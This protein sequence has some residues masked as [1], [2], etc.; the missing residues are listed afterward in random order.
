MPV[1]ATCIAALI[2][3]GLI[4]AQTPPKLEP[5]KTVVTVTARPEPVE[6]SAAD[7]TVVDLERSPAASPQSFADILR[8]QPGLYIGQTG[9]R[10]GLTVVSLRGGDPNFTLFMLDG[11]PVN[12][13]TDQLGGTVDLS[14]IL[15]V[16]VGRVEVVRGPMSVL[17][18]SEAVAGVINVISTDEPKEHAA[19]RL[20]TGSF[21]DLDGGFSVGGRKGR[22]QYNL[23]IAGV[24][25]GEQVERDSFS[26]IDAG[27][28]VSSAIGSNMSIAFIFRIR[29]SEATGFPANSGGP[30]YALNRALETRA[31][32]SG[33][34]G[35]EWKYSI[36]R[37]SHLISGDVFP[38]AQDQ[39]T[40]A[41]F[42]RIPPGFR[43]VPATISSTTFRRTRV[44][45]STSLRIA[46]R[47]TATL[48]AAYRNESGENVGSIAGFGPANYRLDR[49][50]T[51][52]F[53]E[54]VL[55]RR[56]WS[57]VAGVRSDWVSGGYQRISPRVGASAA[58]P[59]KGAR[60]RASWGR[61]FKMPSFY[62]LA[63]P[64]IG[65]AR[66]RPET[67]DAAD[68]ALD[69]KLGGRLGVL[70]ANA[71]RSVYGDLVDFSPQLF[72]LV[73]RSSAEA[74]GVDFSWRLAILGAAL[75]TH[76][77][78]SSIHLRDS[79]E[80]LRDRPR[81]RSGAM[82]S[83]PI[84]AK[85][86][87]YGEGLW[88]ASRF[89]FELPVPQRNRAPSYFVANLGARRRITDALSAY[90][91]VDNILNRS[92]QEY[93]GFPNPGIQ[94]RVGFDYAWH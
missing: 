71:F 56:F 31:A 34:V 16:N 8:F 79:A 21:G 72:R 58:L 78:Y 42:D 70:S 14:T 15:P 63:Q 65:N 89:D 77:T 28:R 32:T 4:Y 2:M 11:I 67:S 59:W 39:N 13:I 81:W 40:P 60:V 29:R 73:N 49:S 51:A 9:Q 94:V 41:I 57:A 20:A 84:K 82:L 66:L 23:G 54:T 64:F 37:W 24:R 52:L 74:R 5:V 18:G 85:T 17:H 26:A 90:F 7:I 1:R 93:V 62:A 86:S 43:T 91:R 36:G 69:Q 88:V 55:D 45:G 33:I 44:N 27:G 46:N 80:P 3:A 12:D 83:I 68:A 53:A 35:L 22:F 76:A 50:T 10:G 48:G 19:L 75:Q 6:T 92:F 61:G 38:Q 25:I 30:K 87:V 47:W